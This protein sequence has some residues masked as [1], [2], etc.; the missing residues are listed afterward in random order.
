MEVIDRQ[1]NKQIDSKTAWLR[2]APQ[3]EHRSL[4]NIW[5]ARSPPAK[6]KR[7]A[8][9]CGY[10]MIWPHDISWLYGYTAISCYTSPIIIWLWSVPFF[11][12]SAGKNLNLTWAMLNASR[13]R[14]SVP[15][16]DKR[17]P[18]SRGGACSGFFSNTPPGMGLQNQQ[19]HYT[20]VQTH[21]LGIAHRKWHQPNQ[22]M[23]TVYIL[24]QL[25]R[26]MHL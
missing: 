18:R 16:I 22:P 21:L 12:L 4:A 8:K 23:H 24:M 15:C 10:D 3:C 5:R 26:Y 17:A 13:G 20:G 14:F 11:L 7:I 25:Y 19:F 2:S 9:T 6:A 1:T